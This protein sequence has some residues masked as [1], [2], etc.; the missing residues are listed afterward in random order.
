MR[1][2]RSLAVTKRLAD[3]ISLIRV[4]TFPSHALAEKL[5]VS[6]QTVYRDILC[7]KQQGH[8][9]RSVKRSSTWAYEIAEHSTSRRTKKEL[10]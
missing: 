7:L 5:G 8:Q 2:E 10:R 6:E 3:L 1:Y 4:G 9:I